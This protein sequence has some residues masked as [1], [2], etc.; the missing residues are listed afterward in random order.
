MKKIYLISLILFNL[1]SLNA[2][3]KPNLINLSQ[4]NYCISNSLTP[5][6]LVFFDEFDGNSIDQTK[7]Y[8]FCTECATPPNCEYARLR[9]GQIYLDQNVVVNNGSLKLVTFKQ[10]SSWFGAIR[11]YTSGYIESTIQN[12]KYGKYEIRCK[13]PNGKGFWPAFWTFG[14]DY[15]EIDVFE[16]AGW[17]PNRIYSNIHHMYGNSNP[18]CPFS[19]C[20][21]SENYLLPF[22]PGLNFHLYSVEWDPFFITWYIDNSPIRTVY[23]YF[24]PV[25]NQPVTSCD[26]QSGNYNELFI[27]PSD[28]QKIIANL[29]IGTDPDETDPTFNN[30][31]DNS[32]IFPNQFEI[33]YIR[34]YQ[35]NPI[36]N[37]SGNVMICKGSSSLYTIS[38]EIPLTNTVTWTLS[39]PDWRFENNSDVIVT[40]S[41]T[42]SVRVYSPTLN[43]NT[44][45]TV[46]GSNQCS[47]HSISKCIS[48]YLSTPIFTLKPTKMCNGYRINTTI[49][50][51]CGATS[52]EWTFEPAGN[53]ATIDGLILSGGTTSCE[54][55]ASQTGKYKIIVYAKN[56]DCRIS[57]STNYYY[58]TVSNYNPVICG[59]ISSP[60]LKQSD[61]E[62]A[63]SLVV[64]G[65]S[66]YPNP[67]NGVLNVQFDFIKDNNC[68][69]FVYDIWGKLLLNFE[70]NTSIEDNS[71]SIDLSNL[72]DGVYLIETN[73]NG[74]IRKNKIIINH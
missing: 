66:L 2:Q 19:S 24:Y 30:A 61:D 17:E 3:F 46:V 41:T 63:E 50:P 70:K 25:L 65:L 28:Q 32:T 56:N 8:T 55:N 54:I 6:K 62:G 11:N 29:A 27:F 73:C 42:N 68:T 36:E 10:T 31:P 12:F 26:I 15:Y 71:T 22:N 1:F 59:P 18:P 23:R 69:I 5:W 47:P 38:T 57:T 37:L 49:S 58:L 74:I 13:I 21:D 64:D 44:T 53:G 16:V 7:W 4:Q 34:V 9:P 33:D 51:V 43:S 48:N 40:P 67:T 45:L 14:G 35:R 39:N 72:V 60:Q 52:Y 20:D